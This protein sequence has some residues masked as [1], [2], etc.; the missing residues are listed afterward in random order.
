[1]RRALALAAAAVTA[2]GCGMFAD[3]PGDEELKAR[4]RTDRAAFESALQSIRA[5]SRL[6]G[7]GPWTYS[8]ES[9]DRAGLDPT[10]SAAVRAGF[11]SLGLRWISGDGT[12]DGRIVLVT[13]S[14]DLPGP[15]HRARGF[16]WAPSRPAGEP[17]QEGRASYAEYQP[18]EGN[19]YLF[20]ELVD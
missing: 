20:E 18:L 6:H 1:M 8:L 17:R 4:F 9:L 11:T 3:P 5:A 2:L 19:W 12:S 14:A 13:W 16:A 10:E 15:G 7:R